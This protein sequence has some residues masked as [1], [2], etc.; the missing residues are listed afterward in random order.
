MDV[1]KDIGVEKM[2]VGDIKESKSDSSKDKVV[3]QREEAEGA[4]AAGPS[5]EGGESQEEEGDHNL[6]IVIIMVGM[7]AS[8]KTSLTQRVTSELMRRGTPPYII[9]LDPAC[10]DPPYPVNIDIRDV[11]KYKKVM[12][13]YNLG[14]NGAIVTSLNLFATKFDEV[15][16]ND[17]Q[18][19]F[20][21]VNL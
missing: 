5:T 14:P 3:N 2:E 21:C 9:N 17:I 13:V 19:F 10:H 20:K 6:P 4:A 8:G 1:K 12:D 7:A 11:V 18:V 15:T 16:N